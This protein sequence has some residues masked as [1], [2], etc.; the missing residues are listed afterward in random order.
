MLNKSKFKGFLPNFTL[1]PID[2]N[3]KAQFLTNEKLAMRNKP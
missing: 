1:L 2:T 3:T